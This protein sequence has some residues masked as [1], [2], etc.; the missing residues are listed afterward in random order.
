MNPRP[1]DGPGGPGLVLSLVLRGAGAVGGVAVALFGVARRFDWV[2]AWLLLA[3]LVVLLA[4]AAIDFS[5]RDP[6]LLRER[7]DRSPAG[8]P[9]WD[10][11]L[12]ALYAIL[13]MVLLIVAGVENRLGHPPLAV[14]FSAGGIAGVLVASAI[15]W[16]S[17]A[18]NHY[19]G[20]F[21]RIQADRGHQVA[22]AG[23]YAIVRHPMYV[24]IML[25]M[26]SIALDWDRRGRCGR[27]WAS[28]SS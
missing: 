20:S 22:T 9:T 19:L 11:V 25:M 14:A 10:R 3:L 2:N 1:G 16:W 5:R 26:A 28:P 12:V 13:F 21:V 15:I 24:A 23:P 7:L 6:D 27:Q 17:A 4:S 18:N 8:V